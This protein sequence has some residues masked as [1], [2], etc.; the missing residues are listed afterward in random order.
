MWVRRLALVFL[1]G[2][3]DRLADADYQGEPLLTLSGPVVLLDG[4][5]FVRLV[6]C[7]LDLVACE[8]ECD[9][10]GRCIKDH[11]ACVDRQFEED[12]ALPEL[13]F[14]IFWADDGEEEEPP[15]LQSFS[16]VTTSFP[17]RWTL[18]IYAPPPA[19]VVTLD[20]EHGRYGL[21]LLL[22]WIDAN[23]N[24]RWDRGRD[25]IVGGAI[26]RAVVYTPDGVSHPEVGDLPAGFHS[27]SLV[28]SCEEGEPRRFIEDGDAI[29]LELSFEAGFENRL[30]ADIDCADDE[31]EP[32]ET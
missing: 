30:I 18:S 22:V 13:Q 10:C 27:M 20:G 17:A 15:T 32:E 6:G 3:G 26:N 12:A 19:G 4:D 1:F 28:P 14:G 23:K 29:A 8:D 24:G 16:L 31:V 25:P 7:E 21:G 11:V 5:E 9:E 2:C